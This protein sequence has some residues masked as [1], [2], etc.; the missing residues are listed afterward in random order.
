MTSTMGQDEKA[1]F[2]ALLSKADELKAREVAVKQAFDQNE[3][4]KKVR[5]INV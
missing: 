4:A 2:I 5:S 1:A 3:I